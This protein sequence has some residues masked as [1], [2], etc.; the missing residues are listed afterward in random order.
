[1]GLMDG[2]ATNQVQRLNVFTNGSTNGNATAY[3][4][5][6]KGITVVSDIDDILRITKIWDPKE[7]IDNTF[8]RPVCLL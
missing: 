1:M 6:P 4:V 5:P 7:I 8:A 2:N 3:L